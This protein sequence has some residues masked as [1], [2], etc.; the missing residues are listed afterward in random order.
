MKAY[1][2]L[3]FLLAVFFALGLIW[4]FWP[5]NGVRVSD[6]LV[7]RFA[8]YQRESAAAEDPPEQELNIDSLL[9]GVNR[10]I[11][12]AE[13]LLVKVALGDSSAL[14]QYFTELM[15]NEQN[16][17]FLPE[18]DYSFFDGLFAQM[19]KARE[20]GRLVRVMHYGDSQIEMDRISGVFRQRL[21]ERFGG[22]GPGMVPAIQAL[23]GFSLSQS[24]SGNL[25]R[26]TMYGDSTTRRAPHKRYG[27]MCQLAQLSGNATISFRISKNRYAQPLVK[28]FSRITLLFGNNSDGFNATLTCD[29]L[30]AI[31]R[32]EPAAKGGVSAFTWKLPQNISKGSLKL[33]GRAEIYGLLVDGGNGVTVDNNGLRGC[34]GFIF[35]SIDSTVLRQSFGLLDTR[36]IILQ[37]GGNAIV[38]M[39]TTGLVN[40]YVDRMKKQIEYFHRVAPDALVMF[41]GPSDMAYSDQTTGSMR[42]Y[43]KLSELNDSLKAM[44]LR[45]G[46]AYWDL[47]NMMGGKNS[48]TRWVHH[49]PAYAGPDYI[50]F[51]NLGAEHVGNVLAK[52]FLFYYEFYR[53]RTYGI[54]MQRDS[55]N[56]LPELKALETG[57]SET[58]NMA[59]QAGSSALTGN[60]PIVAGG[61]PATH[62]D[63]SSS[64]TDSSRALA[65]DSL[66]AVQPGFLVEILDTSALA[67]G[68]VLSAK[69]SAAAVTGSALGEEISDSPEGEK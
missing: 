1:K 28:E 15:E 67:T 42:S 25:T 8:S 55:V 57:A 61:N 39:N 56:L 37:F 69:D 41:I 10:N 27:P 18:D 22:S 50:H 16:Q 13:T 3:L 45:S 31:V 48:M 34:A 66:R 47:F 49:N 23:P 38:G 32:T 6:K 43:P 46:A 5:Q 53:Q 68:G 26:Y 11:D 24:Y 2:I 59:G 17:L 20:E 36:L 60:I 52:S 35:T 64:S 33:S 40:S 63:N 29:S 14:S 30:K 65:G 62:S 7:L 12:M 9:A 54:P 51:T 21:Q 44:S 58:G 4:Y 19:E